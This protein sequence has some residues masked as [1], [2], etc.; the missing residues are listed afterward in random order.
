MIGGKELIRDWT[1]GQLNGN[2]TDRDPEHRVDDES[3]ENFFSLSVDLLCIASIQGFFLRLNPNFSRLLGYAEQELLSRPFLELVHPDDVASTEA[4]VASLAAGQPVIRFRNRFRKV[5]GAYLWIEWSARAIPEKEIIFAIGRDISDERRIVELQSQLQLATA[6]QQKLFPERAPVIAGLD[7][8]GAA[9]PVAHLCG[10]YYDFIVTGPRQ[11]VVVAGDVS[12]HGLGPALA[13]VEVRSVLRGLLQ[14]NE[15]N[16]LPQIL[17]KLNQ[18]LCDD[19]PEGRF[20]TLFLAEID[21]DRQEVRHAGAGHQA[22][23]FHAH[24]QTTVLDSIG[25]VLGVIKSATFPMPRPVPVERSDLLL[26]CTDGVTESMNRE[27]E[28]FGNRKLA[29]FINGNSTDASDEILRKLFAHV[30][31]F[32]SGYPVADDMTAIV[33]KFE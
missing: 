32:T 22:M 17:W 3:L 31:E 11:I 33:A 7:I 16:D 25:P 20:V 29:D 18:L 23:L 12:G 26:I 30:F 19:L 27:R 28:Q 9:V 4:A 1:T 5:Q 6:F 2:A 8:A 14:N 24:R 21:L 13:M 15:V 10:D